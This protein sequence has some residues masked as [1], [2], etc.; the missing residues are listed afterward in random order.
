MEDLALEALGSMVPRRGECGPL[1]MLL[2]KLTLRVSTT[3]SR[4][5]VLGPVDPL[6]GERPPCVGDNVPAVGDRE[7]RL[8]PSGPA[9]LVAV[10]LCAPLVKAGPVCP[11]LDVLFLDLRLSVS[12]DGA[13][14]A[15]DWSACWYAL[16]STRFQRRSE[17]TTFTMI[18][19]A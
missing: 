5:A 19:E 4:S 7:R 9:E 11:L 18:W 1:C 8:L 2:C 12:C 14:A 6:V 3:P 17:L 10:R 15:D 16:D 13:A